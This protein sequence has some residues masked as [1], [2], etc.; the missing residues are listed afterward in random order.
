MNTENVNLMKSARESLEGNW[1]LAVGVFV[2]YFLLTIGI[3]YMPFIGSFIQLIIAGPLILGMIIFVLSIARN[4]KA[5]FEQLFLGFQNFGTAIGAYLLMLLF[6]ILWSLLLIIPG[7]IAA[8]SYSMTFFIIADNKSIGPLEAIRKSKEMMK[9]YK[10]K[11]VCLSFRFLGWSL[12]A[13]LTL[14]IGYLW[15]I[16]YMQVSYA[17]FYDDIK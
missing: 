11:I 16:P 1:L 2:V 10:W 8:L 12:L 7:I 5:S 13:M 4:K 15:L 6:I 3:S 9:G 14:G 17:K